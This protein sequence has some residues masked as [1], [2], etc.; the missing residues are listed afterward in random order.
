LE[1]NK[2]LKDAAAKTSA[3]TGGTLDH[4]IINGAYLSSD[5][6]HLDPTEFEGHEDQLT[7][8]L[9]RSAQ[10]NIAGNMYTINAFLPLIRKGNAKKI[11]SISSGHA[12]HEVILQGDIPTSVVYSA[13]KAA[14]NVVI[15]KYAAEL[16]PEGIKFL[17]LS[18]GAVETNGAPR[19]STSI[20][21]FVVVDPC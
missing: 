3:I 17:S 21:P 18:P 10:V 15:A 2:S 6:W 4:L 7:T 11:V 19:K 12:A 5:S 9:T 16:R 1:D 14:L 13:M 8:D 20:R